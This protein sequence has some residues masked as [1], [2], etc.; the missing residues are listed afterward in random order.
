MQT[1]KKALLIINPKAGKR[2]SSHFLLEAIKKLYDAD[3]EVCVYPTESR[4]ETIQKLKENSYIYD[5]IVCCGGD[6]TLNAV[7]S[8]LILGRSRVPIGYIP[9]GTTNDFATTL[10]IPKNY[11][12][13]LNSIVEGNIMKCDIGKFNSSLFT[14]IAAA[15]AFTEVSYD[16]PS[17]MKS[18]FGHLAYVLEGIKSISSLRSFHLKISFDDTVIEDD[19]LYVSV[20]NT[21]SIGGII[22]LEK[23]KVEL[24]DGWFELL[25]IKSPK[26]PA[27]LSALI[28]SIVTADF[29][30]PAFK[31]YYVKEVQIESESPIPWTLD[32]E[33]GGKHK[34]VRIEN[35]RNAWRL[36]K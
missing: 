28:N 27:Q 3:Y 35:H 5:L 8:G 7:V 12:D 13:A 30:K 33:N 1:S 36:I 22:K 11:N 26:N 34:N 19:F 14:Y 31:I 4:E 16:T 29:S 6:G 10:K 9:T 24:N 20:S 17:S 32:G 15:G 2:L 18:T 25:L 21:T 23:A